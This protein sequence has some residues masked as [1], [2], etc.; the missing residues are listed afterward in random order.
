MTTPTGSREDPI[1]FK[2]LYDEDGIKWNNVIL[3]LVV[4]ALSGYIAV[5]AQRMA[6]SSI[7][8]IQQ[9]KMKTAQRQITIGQ[10]IRRLGESIEE[11]GWVR[12]ERIRQ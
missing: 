3:G 12:Y 11:G 7:D 2:W 10:S 8:P 5:K 6:S 9:L 1:Y 4:T